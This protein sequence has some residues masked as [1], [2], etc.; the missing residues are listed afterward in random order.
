MFEC[1]GIYVAEG[2]L[3]SLLLFLTAGELS[4]KFKASKSWSS[5]ISGL[6]C[7][8]SSLDCKMSLICISIA[9]SLSLRSSDWN[10]FILFNISL[11]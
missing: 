3:T 1:I 2:L 10:Y 11:S 6:Y 8:F 4:V 9:E 5:D 7:N